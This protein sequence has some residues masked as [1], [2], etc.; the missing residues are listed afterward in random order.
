ME[1]YSIKRMVRIHFPGG[2]KVLLPEDHENFKKYLF[3]VKALWTVI[4]VGFISGYAADWL[5]GHETKF[6]AFIDNQ[7]S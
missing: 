3:Y 4:I 7:F 5:E 1:N 2:K 6:R